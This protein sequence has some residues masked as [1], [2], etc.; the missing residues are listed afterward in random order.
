ML[1]FG[2]TKFLA[3]FG[4]RLGISEDISI[5]KFVLP[6]SPSPEFVLLPHGGCLQVQFRIYKKMEP[7]HETIVGYQ[8]QKI[9]TMNIWSVFS[10]IT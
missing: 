7:W 10:D 4:G 9:P 1:F 5:N 3:Y 2:E 6:H 8:C